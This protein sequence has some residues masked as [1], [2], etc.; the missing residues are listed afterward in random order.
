M[1]KDEN[2]RL[3]VNATKFIIEYP[4]GLE[5]FMPVD[6]TARSLILLNRPEVSKNMEK[7]FVEQGEIKSAIKEL[8]EKVNKLLVEYQTNGQKLLDYIKGLNL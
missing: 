4:A 5:K 1:N 6:D 3:Y 2:D 8:Y 7:Y